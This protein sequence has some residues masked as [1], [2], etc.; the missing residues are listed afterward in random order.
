MFN[1]LVAEDDKNIQMLTKIKLT[2]EGFNVSVASNGEE[3]IQVFESKPIDLIILDLMMPKMDGFEVLKSIRQSNK[4]I[5]IIIVSAK[6]EFPDKAKAFSDGVDDYMV[7]PINFNE[8]ILRIKALLRRA[9]IAIERKIEFKD[10]I[11]DYDSLSITRKSTNE[12]VVLTKK[13]FSIRH[14]ECLLCNRY[15]RCGRLCRS[16]V[17]W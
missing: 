10:I 15:C 14:E 6:S 3:V 1:I 5:P 4:T 8:L 11:L 2:D 9:Q 7:K 16:R 12:K 13:E 17:F